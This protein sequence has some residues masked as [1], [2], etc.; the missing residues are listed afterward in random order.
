M[1]TFETV[2]VNIVLKIINA[3]SKT[4]LSKSNQIDNKRSKD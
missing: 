3:I 2:R 4:R 1:F